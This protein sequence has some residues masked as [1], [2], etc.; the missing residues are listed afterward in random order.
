M[1]KQYQER[2]K[3]VL[4]MAFEDY[5]HYNKM[6][7]SIYLESIQIEKDIFNIIEKYFEQN[8]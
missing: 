4:S 5:R 6:R 3:E 1:N 8:V 2:L 7:D